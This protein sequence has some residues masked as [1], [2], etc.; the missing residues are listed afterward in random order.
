MENTLDFYKSLGASNPEV[1]EDIINLSLSDGVVPSSIRYLQT[2]GTYRGAIESS[3]NSYYYFNY[4]PDHN[5]KLVKAEKPEQIKEVVSILKSAKN[6][7]DLVKKDEDTE[8][9]AGASG[10]GEMKPA[11]NSTL[12]EEDSVNSQN[13]AITQVHPGAAG[14][15]TP[16]NPN[17]GKDWHGEQTVKSWTTADL[18][19]SWSE[20]LQETSNIRLG[21]PRA[22]PHEQAFLMDF[23]GYGPDE[24]AKVVLTPGQKSKFNVW[25]QTSALKAVKS[26]ANWR[27][28]N[29]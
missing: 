11:G 26:L 19:K 10:G 12:T 3:N 20:H 13:S 29:G 17:R 8:K 27:K 25:T 7:L 2:N 24:A 1:E 14:G 22:T 15:I 5:F 6:G 21:P 9:A 28:K 23:Y 16:D 18:L 4:F